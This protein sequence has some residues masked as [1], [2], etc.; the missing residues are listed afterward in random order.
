MWLF[1]LFLILNLVVALYIWFDT[2]AFV[3][4]ASLLRIRLLKYKEY[5]ENKKSAIP[6]IAAQS[7]T[8]FIESTYG[9]NSFLCRLV[10]C[11][12]CFTVWCNVALICVFYSR[13]NVLLLGP[14]ILASWLLY[15]S[16]RW[17]LKKL[18]E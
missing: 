12:V 13:I 6:F 8:Q 14:N 11:P 16:L 10:T 4:W 15:H 17:I 3:E 5:A 7:Y 1:D 18:N 2:D 9:P